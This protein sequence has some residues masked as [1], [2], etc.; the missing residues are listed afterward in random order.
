[1][2]F[3][4]VIIFIDIGYHILIS[5]FQ[6]ICSYAFI[7]GFFKF[8]N[9]IFIVILI[10][11]LMSY[12]IIVHL[13]LR[14]SKF[15]GFIYIQIFISK[16]TYFF[17]S[18]YI[19]FVIIFF[20]VRNILYNKINIRMIYSYFIYWNFIRFILFFLQFLDF[21]TCLIWRYNLNLFVLM[22]HSLRLN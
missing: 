21:W 5:L 12:N 3:L 13:P 11:L 20:F 15:P 9:R 10:K 1:M 22:L 6:W 2:N 4:I 7:F 14:H 18:D 17:N 19:I 8:S 16:I